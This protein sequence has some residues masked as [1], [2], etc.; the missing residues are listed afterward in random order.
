MAPSA[1][2]STA[3]IISALS[4]AGT[5]L[6]QAKLK[7]YCGAKGKA[8]D[9]RQEMTRTMSGVDCMWEASITSYDILV[10]GKACR[11]K[12]GRMVGGC[13]I[14]SL[15]NVMDDMF[16]ELFL[17]LWEPVDPVLWMGSITSQSSHSAWCGALH[18]E[19]IN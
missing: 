6:R 14:C 7:Q 1:A 2:G 15:Q 11:D 4:I 10:R 18:Q 8:E 16:Y 19:L 3:S 17:F 12:D 9:D 5:A 13:S